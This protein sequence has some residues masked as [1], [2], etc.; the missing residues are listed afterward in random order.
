[1]CAISEELVK[2]NYI[3]NFL[4]ESLPRDKNTLWSFGHSSFS[5]T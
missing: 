5:V 3:V 1:M 4:A 2:V